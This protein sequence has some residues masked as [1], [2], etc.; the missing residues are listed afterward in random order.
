PITAKE[1]KH[2]WIEFH[3][4]IRLMSGTRFQR[5]AGRIL[6]EDTL[7]YRVAR[8]IFRPALK[9]IRKLRRMEARKV[10]RVSAAKATEIFPVNYRPR[11]IDYAL[12]LAAMD[13]NLGDVSI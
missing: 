12:E 9:A 4:Q 10:T 13:A 6:G 5:A 3:R 8:F 2:R 11:T 7:R 1:I